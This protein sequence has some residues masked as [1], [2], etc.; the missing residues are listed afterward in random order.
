M[1][2]GDRGVLGPI[3]QTYK[4]PQV[5]LPAPRVRPLRA[6]P[7]TR[8]DFFRPSSSHLT[9]PS[10]LTSTMSARPARTRVPSA[11]AKAAKATPVKVEKTAATPKKASTA[12]TPK[13]TPAYVTIVLS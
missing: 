9:S 12:G 8:L 6:L 10:F 11:K 5:S 3:I 7:P 1:V 13:P 2:F 4:D